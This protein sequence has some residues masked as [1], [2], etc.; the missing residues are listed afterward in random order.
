M[1]TKKT[2]TK[3]RTLGTVMG[4]GIAKIVKGEPV[5]VATA[6]GRLAIRAEKRVH[7]PGKQYKVV[8][9]AAKLTHY[10]K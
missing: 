4:W 7:F 1:A 8:Q 10:L 6:D 2:A 5:L 3:N 9:I